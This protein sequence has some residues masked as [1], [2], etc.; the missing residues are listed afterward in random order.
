MLARRIREGIE[1][2]VDHH[3]GPL[4]ALLARH[5]QRIAAAYPNLDDR[6]DFYDGVYDGP[7]RF[8]LS[9]GRSV[10]AESLLA[11]QLLQSQPPKAIRRLTVLHLTDPDS[12]SVTLDGLRALNTADALIYEQCSNAALSVMDLARRDAERYLDNAQSR[13]SADQF[14]SLVS[15]VLDRHRQVVV[16]CQSAHSVE[17]CETA[18]TSLGHTDVTFE[19]VESGRRLRK[20]ASRSVGDDL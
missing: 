13:R 16:L 10:Q 19:L 18:C 6:R 8:L 14:A 5:R 17:A 11:N 20:S 12:G 15:D 4:A 1:A 3:T 2:M 9:Q 7:V